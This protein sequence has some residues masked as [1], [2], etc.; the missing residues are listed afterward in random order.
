MQSDLVMTRLTRR[1]D[2]RAKRLAAVSVSSLTSGACESE[3]KFSQVFPMLRLANSVTVYDWRKEILHSF[4]SVCCCSSYSLVC[5]KLLP[6]RI[7]LCQLTFLT[8]DTSKGY[9]SFNSMIK[10]SFKYM[11]GQS[12]TNEELNAPHW[13]IHF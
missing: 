5:S 10:K 3:G 4:S 8:L 13:G 9:F 1:T 12:L 7:K 2:V 6:H 11:C